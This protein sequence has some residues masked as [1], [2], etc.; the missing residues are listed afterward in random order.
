MPSQLLHSSQ[1]H[2]LHDQ[3]AD[4]CMAQ[5]VPAEVLHLRFFNGHLEPFPGIIQ[6]TSVLGLKDAATMGPDGK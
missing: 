1:I 3:A 2:I 4:E 5:I 6:V